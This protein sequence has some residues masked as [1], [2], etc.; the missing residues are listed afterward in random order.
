MIVEIKI[1][2][3]GSD[4]IMLQHAWLVESGRVDVAQADTAE[5]I[6]SI[7]GEL[8]SDDQN[9]VR[10]FNVENILST[11]FGPDWEYFVQAVMVDEDECDIDP[12]F[13]SIADKYVFCL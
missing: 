4:E 10:D 5:L 1:V 2:K 12:E 9:D 6:E 8:D 11:R 3:A 7:C 13:D